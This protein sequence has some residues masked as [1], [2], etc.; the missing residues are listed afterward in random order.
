MNSKILK[1]RRKKGRSRLY[2]R[3][4]KMKALQEKSKK[5]EQLAQTM[6]EKIKDEYSKAIPSID[7]K[8]ARTEIVNG[9]VLRLSFWQKY[10]NEFENISVEGVTQYLQ[11]NTNSLIHQIEQNGYAEDVKMRIEELQN[12]D[13]ETTLEQDG[14]TRVMKMLE[15]MKK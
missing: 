10:I 15:G 8:G 14:N 3:K 11:K 5:Q 9:L 4:H 2:S 6:I 1:A 12:H 13:E 7:L